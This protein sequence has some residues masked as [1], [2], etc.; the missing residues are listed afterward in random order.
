[1]LLGSTSVVRSVLYGDTRI[2]YTTFDDQSREVLRLPEAPLAVRAG[3][4][5]L[6]RLNNLQRNVQGYT[7]E[8]IAGGGFVI[9]IHHKNSGNVRIQ[10]QNGYA[11]TLP[12]DRFSNGQNP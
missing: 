1:H 10:L 7:V 12:Q 11:S 8:A 3:S 6:S 5:R 2:D 4:K 9:R